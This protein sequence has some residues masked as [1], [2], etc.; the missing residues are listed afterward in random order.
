MHTNDGPTT[1]LLDHE[2]RDN[3]LCC[4]NVYRRVGRPKTCQFNFET[5][6]LE[7]ELG[8]AKSL[9]VIQ[10]G[11]VIYW[12]HVSEA[13]SWALISFVNGTCRLQYC[14]TTISSTVYVCHSSGTSGDSYGGAAQLGY[15]N[16]LLPLWLLANGCYFVAVP[17]KLVFGNLLGSCVRLHLHVF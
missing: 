10:M 2:T 8:C 16:L 17:K 7:G 14:V 6:N 9:V 15:I 3:P 13:L 1:K 11:F 4:T 12:Y 5:G